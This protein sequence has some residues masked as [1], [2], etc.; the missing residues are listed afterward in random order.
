MREGARAGRSL[1]VLLRGALL[2]VVTAG[3]GELGDVGVEMRRVV[4]VVT[5]KEQRAAAGLRARRARYVIGEAERRMEGEWRKGGTVEN[6]N[7]T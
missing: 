4:G 5:A 1:R 2:V 6:G 3:D 7:W